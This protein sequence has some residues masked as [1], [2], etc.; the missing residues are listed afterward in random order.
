MFLQYAFIDNSERAFNINTTGTVMKLAA[1]PT[2]GAKAPAIK[3]V[4][5]IVIILLFLFISSLRF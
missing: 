5:E 1:I 3:E 2:E 4:V